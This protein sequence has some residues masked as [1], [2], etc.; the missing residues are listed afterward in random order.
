M[1]QILIQLFVY[2]NNEPK[3]LF[4]PVD[5]A[6]CSL[7]GEVDL[8]SKGVACKIWHVKYNSELIELL[9]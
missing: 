2:Y 5:G 9:W 4:S 1:L 6:K 7:Y 3:W 8:H